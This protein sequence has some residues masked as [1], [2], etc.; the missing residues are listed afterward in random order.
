MVR[1]V[2]ATALGDCCGCVIF[3]VVVVV[4][5]VGRLEDRAVP[6]RSC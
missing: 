1:G 2:G 5:V 6:F 4:V 3:V